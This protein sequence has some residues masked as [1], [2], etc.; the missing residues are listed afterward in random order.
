MEL[1]L[2]DGVKLSAPNNDIPPRKSAI[3][4]S[5]PIWMKMKPVRPEISP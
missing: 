2:Q 3:M 1:Q 5:E 4:L